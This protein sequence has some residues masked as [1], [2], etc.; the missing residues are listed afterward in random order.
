LATRALAQSPSDGAPPA[1]SASSPTDA[2]ETQPLEIKGFRS[3]AFG[4]SEAEVRAA[5]MKDFGLSA[6]AIHSS[7]DLAERTQVLT[8]RVPDVLPDGGAAD[9]AYTLG[10]KS[11]KLIQVAVTWSKQTDDKL[12]AE[13]LLQNGESLRNYFQAQG[14][15]PES[16]A[17]NAAVKDGV[18]LFRGADS[19][20]RTTVL[21]LRG[22]ASGDK[23]A[24][25]FSPSA[26]V[27]LYLGDTKNPDVYR[28]PAGKF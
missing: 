2:S 23:A 7:Q 27:L 19:Q 26:L 5:A 14:Y 20:G 1:A 11:K 17:A 9:V 15:V 13:R 8:V 10:Y 22:A 28:V 21:L 12:T 18:L 16:V 4:S 24:R 25:Q 6:D 3:A